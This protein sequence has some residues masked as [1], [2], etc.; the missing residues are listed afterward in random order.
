MKTFATYLIDFDATSS[1]HFA[2]KRSRVLTDGRRYLYGEDKTALR[3]EVFE[4]DGYRCVGVPNGRQCGR[5][6]T[7]ET[8]EMSH[9]PRR[10]IGGDSLETCSLRCR[11]CHRLTDGHGM[12]MHF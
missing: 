12:P 4:R 11:T 8:G 1:A 7:W 2:D 6:L 9:Y 10:P 3:R 5:S